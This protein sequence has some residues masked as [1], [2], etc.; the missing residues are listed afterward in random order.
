MKRELLNFRADPDMAAALR[1]QAALEQTTV[2]QILRDA[3]SACIYSSSE[4]NPM[5]SDTNPFKRIMPA[6][7]GDLE[8]QRAFVA[9]SL[10]LGVGEG[11]FSCVIEGLIFARLAAAQGGEDDVA[12][13][14][15]LMGTACEMLEGDEDWSD[16]TD[17]LNGEA[18]AIVSLLAERGVDWADRVLPAMAEYS[19]SRAAELAKI[20]RSMM[21]AT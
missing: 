12:N 1:D 18:L 3:L 2:S 20:V 8:A 17:A 4:G 13:L 19:T 6:A 11:D 14:L 5:T 9:D 15:I 21:P 7:Q 10:R 16:Y